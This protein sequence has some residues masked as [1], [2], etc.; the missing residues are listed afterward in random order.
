MTPRIVSVDIFYVAIVLVGFWFPWPKAS[1]VLAA[2]ASALIIGG[3]WLAIP[4]N[5]AP[6][7]NWMNRACAVA[8]VWIAAAFVWYIRVLAQKLQTQIEIS[9]TLSREINH[10]VGNSLQLV[11]SFLRLREAKAHYEE[12]R[13]A[14]KA[15]GSQVMVIGKIQ[16]MLS[17]SGSTGAVNSESFIKS[18]IGDLCATA[19]DRDAMRITVE[20]D[21]A[22]LPS[23]TAIA[24]GAL[25]SELINNALK[26]A[27]PGLAGGALAIRFFN[28]QS[29]SQYVLEVEDDG[30]GIGPASRLGGFGFETVTELARLMRGSVTHQAVRASDTRPG[31]KWRLVVPQGSTAKR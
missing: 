11:A 1:F 9:N 16:R 29:P 7:E 5:V 3:L 21:A 8:T 2:L 15:A 13:Q 6:W 27:F 4:D 10:R 26:H 28:Q 22:E 23:T 24:L 30:I 17:H 12:S 20:A 14:L 19:P 31:T 25:L 18:L